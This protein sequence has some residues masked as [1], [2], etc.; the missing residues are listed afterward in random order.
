V[1]LKSISFEIFLTFHEIKV[2]NIKIVNE[3]FGNIAQFKYF[4]TTLTNQNDIHDEV[5]SR[6]NSGNACYYSVQNLLSSRLISKNLKIRIFK[7]GHVARMGEG[8]GV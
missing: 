1:L 2:Q 3:S 6:L 8:R 7:T 4:G 5:K